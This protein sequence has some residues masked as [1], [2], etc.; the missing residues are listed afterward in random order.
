[1]PQPCTTLFRRDENNRF[2]LWS[3]FDGRTWTA[4]AHIPGSENH[5]HAAGVIEHNGNLH[6]LYG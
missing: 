6:M 1:M 3:A 2:M 5:Q 4:S